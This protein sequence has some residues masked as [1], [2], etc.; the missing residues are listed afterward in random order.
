MSE[1]TY[2]DGSYRVVLQFPGNSKST[3]YV[4]GSNRQAAISLAKREF[5]RGSMLS[6]IRRDPPE[7]AD[8]LSRDA[9]EMSAV[10]T[11]DNEQ[12]EVTQ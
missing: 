9:G 7:G 12:S 4:R 11:T 8:K 5:Q 10:S 1:D 6:C 2:K 3:V